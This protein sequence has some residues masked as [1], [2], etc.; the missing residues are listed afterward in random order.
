MDTDEIVTLAPFDNSQYV[1]F[2]VETGKV[3]KVSNEF[4][5]TLT[6]IK[7]E[8]IDIEK[9]VEGTASLEDYRVVL[10]SE[11]N[12]YVLQ[13]WFDLTLNSMTASWDYLIYQIPK[14]PVN[15]IQY[16][17]VI[18]QDRSQ[19]MWTFRINWNIL[20]VFTFANKQNNRY[21]E[22]YVTE[23][24]DANALI[25][26]LRFYPSDVNKNGE[27]HICNID[28]IQHVNIYCRKIFQSYLHKVI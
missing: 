12:E 6:S 1:Y 11:T 7:V 25:S 5:N 3:L 19:N 13:T 26:T 24:D 15:N 28:A 20:D 16:D 9:I 27:F 10:N 8:Y 2:D 21:L 23:L 18:V 22:F 17:L 14:T 4:D